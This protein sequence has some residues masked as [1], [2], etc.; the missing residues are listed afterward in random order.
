MIMKAGPNNSPIRY[1]LSGG[2]YPQWVLLIHAAFADHTMFREQIE[3]FQDKYN[4]IA[5]DIIGHGESTHTRRGDSVSGMSEWIYE[6][7]EAEGIDKIHIAGVSLGAVLAQDFANHHP[8]RVSS[9]ACFGGYDI[10]NFDPAMQ[11][12]NGGKQMAMMLKA[13]FSLK[14]FA[15][16]NRQISAHT[17]KARDDFYEMNL[18]FPKKSFMYLAG[19]D[20][21]VNKC[22]TGERQYPLMI[23]CG[24]FDIPMELEAVKQWKAAEPDCEEV[25]F[26]NAG[27][28][29]NMDA[30]MEFN[31][32]METFWGRER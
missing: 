21:M 28:C 29:V 20:S 1:F 19:L 15:K 30:P 31:R 14:S 6:I 26:R 16:A 17:Q 10:N 27:H 3:Y 23:G 22:R 4:L 13:I 12:E 5:V 25:I 18:R 9:L 8:D 7:L 2:R 32:T 11:K 24:E